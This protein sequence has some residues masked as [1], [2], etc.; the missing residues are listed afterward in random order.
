MTYIG[1]L[2]IRDTTFEANQA[3]KEG[4]AIMSLGVLE[5]GSLTRVIFD[6]NVPHCPA[7]QYG[8]EEAVE[9]SVRKYANLKCDVWNTSFVFEMLDR[10]RPV[11]ALSGEWPDTRKVDDAPWTYE[12]L[13][14]AANPGPCIGPNGTFGRAPDAED[15]VLL[16]I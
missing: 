5:D 11:F 2:K 10:S 4:F 7:G 3:D 1:T 15:S 8:Y 14:F 13:N 9:N 16:D 12:A 6:S